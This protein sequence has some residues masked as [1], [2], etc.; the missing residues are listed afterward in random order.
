MVERSRSHQERNARAARRGQ[1]ATERTALTD[2]LEVGTGCEST[3]GRKMPSLVTLRPSQCDLRTNDMVVRCRFP[4]AVGQDRSKR[5]DIVTVVSTST[6][7]D[8]ERVVELE[9]SST[10]VPFQVP[11]M[12]KLVCPT[13]VGQLAAPVFGPVLQQNVVKRQRQGSNDWNVRAIRI[14]RGHRTNDTFEECVPRLAERRIFK[15]H[16][17]A[18]RDEA[19]KLSF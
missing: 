12:M 16:R 2:V 8:I 4:K 3:L 13:Y 19:I 15:D 5:F 10:E 6:S 14:R 7:I 11:A 17:D 18:R 1:L 9:V